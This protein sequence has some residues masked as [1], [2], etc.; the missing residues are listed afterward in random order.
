VDLHFSP[1]IDPFE[2]VYIFGGALNWENAGWGDCLNLEIRANPSPVVPEPPASSLGLDV[3]YILDEDRIMYA[4]PGSG[5]HA[6]G[7]YPVWVPNF[8]NKGH[9]NLDKVAMAA[10]PAASGTGAFDWFTTEQFVGHYVSD[11]VIYGSTSNPVI[12]D[13]TESAPL[14]QGHWL[15]LRVHNNTNTD[16]KVWGFMKMYRERLK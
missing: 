8:K 12:I 16:F 6:L 10:V 7:G 11:M 5:T 2:T 14:P 9:W 1:E 15:R 3:N 4:G 13:A